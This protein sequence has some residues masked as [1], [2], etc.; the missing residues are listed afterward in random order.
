[1]KSILIDITC[2][3]K[4][5]HKY[6]TGIPRVVLSYVKYYKER[7]QAVIS[8]RGR[9][10]IVFSKDISY[11]IFTAI[12][13]KSKSLNLS[14]LILK[15]TLLTPPFQKINNGILLKI[16]YGML[17]HKN[18]FYLFKKKK[19]I[20]IISMIYDLIPITHP[21]YFPKKD[22]EMF[23]PRIN[24]ILKISDGIICISNATKKDLIDFA[25]YNKKQT[26]PIISA[27]LA[28][29]LKQIAPATPL[30]GHPYFVILGTIEPRKNH[31]L[32]F[33]IWS[34]LIDLCG[35]DTPKLVIIG[36]RRAKEP[37]LAV[38]ILDRSPKLKP[39][40]IEHSAS[41]EEISN[42][43]HYAQ[44]LL[45]PTFSEGYGLPIIEALIAGT[46]VIASD[47]PVFK[48]IA[49]DIPE[50]ISPLDGKKWLGTIIDYTNPHSKARVAQLNRIANFIPPTWRDHFTQVDAF[51]E[52]L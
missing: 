2:L 15:K 38:K 21:E 3:L 47:L 8:R 42:Y 48:E 44:A 31:V 23:E 26:P 7:A 16:D 25:S 20:K 9:N 49:G 33:Q 29:D 6:P 5:T 11:E 32:L 18:Y 12:L 45:F 30:L 40:I 1:M 13:S 27:L 51:L 37:G 34:H 10:P 17:A 24:E 39:F 52:S 35:K 4:L 46:P 22:Q 28:T 50:Y 14:L 43:L 19:G 36:Q 41:D